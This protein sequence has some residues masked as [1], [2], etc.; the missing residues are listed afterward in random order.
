M[1]LATI[2]NGTRDGE[3][4]VVSS[5]LSRAVSARVIA[6]NLLT[7][8]ED[9]SAAEPKLRTLAEDLAAG[10]AGETFAFDQSIVLSP[11]PRS[12][13][14]I[15]GS[16]FKNHLYLM[17]RAT[18]RDPEIEM[19]SP[20]PLMYQG[21]SDDFYR[22]HGDIPLPREEDNIDFEAEVGIVL[23]E[24]P[25]GTTAAEAPKY[26]KLVLLIND[27]SC[28][29]YVKREITVGFG[30]MNAK[31]S[32]AFSPVAITPD[33][34]GAA[35]TG[36]VE[37][38]IRIEWNGERF[39]EP[40]GREMSFS[41]YDLIEHAARTRKLAAGTIFGS[42]TVSNS[43]FKNV[44]SACIAERRSIEML[45]HGEHRTSFMK[46]GDRVRIEMIDAGGK[47]I[48]GAIDQTVVE[49]RKVF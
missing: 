16:C 7:A 14:W 9:W 4:V 41:F 46:F 15:D 22:P 36:K 21:M 24:V 23:D 5:D 30:W 17:A 47:S 43:D 2:P 27:V 48:F 26:V 11:L 35:W 44:G 10:R 1:K 31:P 12:F 42:G 20:F 25:M 19:N 8:F 49:Y 39:G 40:N 28:R 45:E 6:P 13:Q 29:A 34:L 33:E 38:P 3:L 37:L 32:T 18:G